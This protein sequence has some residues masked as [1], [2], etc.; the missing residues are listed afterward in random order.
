MIFM[1]CRICGK[2]EPVNAPPI[3]TL[4]QLGFKGKPTYICAE[5]YKAE[6]VP[7]AGA[8]EKAP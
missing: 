1:G 6:R 4:K 5:C 3:S 2:R 8:K 7:S